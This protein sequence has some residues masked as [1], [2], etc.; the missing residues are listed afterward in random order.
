MRIK[1]T[2]KSWEHQCFI[3]INYQYPLS[4]AI[5]NILSHGSAEYA[6]WLHHKGYLTTD[7]K[8]MKLFN[9]SKL[10]IPNVKLIE[11][12]LLIRGTTTV[13]LYI[14]SPMLEDFIQHFV[15]GLFQHQEIEIRTH[16]INARFTVESVETAMTPEFQSSQKFRCLSPIV[17]SGKHIFDGREQEYFLRPN[18]KE[19][20]EAIRKNL[21]NKYQIVFQKT[22][23]DSS[24][25][26]SLDSDY[27][28]RKGGYDKLSKLIT[29]KEHRQDE[30]TRIKAFETLFTLT[31]N[32]E[33]MQ[34]A[35][36]CGIG[37]RNSLGFGMIETI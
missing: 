28:N 7:G 21:I 37:Q 20:S 11:K 24:L 2:L 14:S 32:P 15:V 6:D 34:I 22:P 27:I 33:L 30:A 35:W 23:E 3:P 26:F 36:E 12:K 19:L 5:Y 16:G 29:I 4:A 31:G 8:P 18:D 1:L 25:Q 9:F 17:I 10:I 13:Q